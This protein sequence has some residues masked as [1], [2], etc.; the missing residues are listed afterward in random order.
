M[1]GAQ[2]LLSGPRL[3]TKAGAPGVVVSLLELVG[4]KRVLLLGVD[5]VFARALVDGCEFPECLER[6][7]EGARR[8]LRS[9]R[10]DG[11]WCGRGCCC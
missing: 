7:R 3:L 5:G 6:S 10:W 8:L 9:R 4:R 1:P 11:E 2:S